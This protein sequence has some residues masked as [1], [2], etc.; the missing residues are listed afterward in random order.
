MVAIAIRKKTLPPLA[1]VDIRQKWVDNETA[2]IN[3][4][5]LKLSIL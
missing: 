5:K 1:P 2:V 4:S 3:I